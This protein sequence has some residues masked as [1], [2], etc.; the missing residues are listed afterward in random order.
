MKLGYRKYLTEDDLWALPKQ[1][2]A[3]SLSERL[4]VN[5]EDQMKKKKCAPLVNRFLLITS[6]HRSVVLHHHNRKPSL[7]LALF[8][9]YGKPF[10]V[11]ALFKAVH[12]VLAFAQP[13]LLRKL[14]SFVSS[15][16][17]S[18]PQPAYQGYIIALGMFLCSLLQTAFLH[19]Y[20]QRVIETGM[21]VRGG[22]VCA[23]YRKAL[24]LSNEER[25]GRQ[26]GD[27]VNLQSTDTT[28]LQDVCNYGQIGECL[29]VTMKILG[30][31]T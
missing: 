24:V 29:G 19:Q 5:W 2:Q 28:R 30:Q 18:D 21:R 9:A 3:D 23:I 20:F 16:S 25:K 12:D 15:Y 13:Q 4:R 31:V 10:F 14:L 27:I 8:K 7:T 17:T 6:K 1:D 11:A 22:L 26:T